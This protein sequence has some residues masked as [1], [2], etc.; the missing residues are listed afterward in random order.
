MTDTTENSLPMD[1]DDGTYLPAPVAEDTEM[2]APETEAAPPGT[3]TGAGTDTGTGE[4]DPAFELP[5]PDMADPGPDAADDAGIDD[6][7]PSLPSAPDLGEDPLGLADPLVPGIDLG[8]IVA[9]P[10]PAVYRNDAV[11]RITGLIA[12][13]E[14]M[15]AEPE[16]IE[17]DP[18]RARAL[19]LAQN[20]VLT[21][22]IDRMSTADARLALLDRGTE[23]ADPVSLISRY[24]AETGR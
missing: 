12:R 22:L 13:Y 19:E 8:D 1:S 10:G 6:S 21:S 23:A 17:T 7:M 24:Y 3:G 16:K 2:H 14:T 4:T 5:L 15:L 20:R 18:A 11:S 9:T